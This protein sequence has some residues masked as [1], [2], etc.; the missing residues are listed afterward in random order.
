[1][2]DTNVGTYHYIIIS[3]ENSTMSYLDAVVQKYKN[4]RCIQYLCKFTINK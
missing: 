2:N 1:M 4:I 3:A